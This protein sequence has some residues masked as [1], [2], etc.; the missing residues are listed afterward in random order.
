MRGREGSAAGAR[1]RQRKPHATIGAGRTRGTGS[2][3]GCENCT[4]IAEQLSTQP[5]S[6][7]A[8]STTALAICLLGLVEQATVR[9]IT[10]ARGGDE[11]TP[12]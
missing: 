1:A 5:F 4:S 9:R 3:C 12:S 7:T 2:C 10:T 11:R 6:K 8:S